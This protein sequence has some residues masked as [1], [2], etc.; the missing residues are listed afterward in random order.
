MMRLIETMQM[1]VIVRCKRGPPCRILR[2]NEPLRHNRIC[3][4]ESV[5]TQW[6]RLPPVMSVLGSRSPCWRRAAP[7]SSSSRHCLYQNLNELEQ[8]SGRNR[9][10]LLWCVHVMFN[11][12]YIYWMGRSLLGPGHGCEGPCLGHA[13]REAG[14]VYKRRMIRIRIPRT[15]CC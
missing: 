6:E 13:R 10:D 3:A 12:V 4:H 7:A 11:G 15:G 9:I 1:N 2:W 8:R 5:R 14:K